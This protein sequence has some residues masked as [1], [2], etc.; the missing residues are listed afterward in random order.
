MTKTA[1]TR[2]GTAPLGGAKAPPPKPT[3]KKPT[4]KK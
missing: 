4:K 3:T 1:T 2:P